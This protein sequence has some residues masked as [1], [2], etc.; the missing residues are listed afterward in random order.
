MELWESNCIPIYSHSIIIIYLWI[1]IYIY[2]YLHLHDLSSVLLHHP[3]IPHQG[4]WSFAASKATH[5]A[6]QVEHEEPNVENGW[7]VV[8]PTIHSM[9][10]SE[11]GAH[12]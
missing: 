9:G 8:K 10:V 1:Y 12:P 2:T 4:T 5:E 6:Q 11:T 3:E 7:F